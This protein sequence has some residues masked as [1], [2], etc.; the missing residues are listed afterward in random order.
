MKIH[1]LVRLSTG[2]INPYDLYHIIINIYK[3][4]EKKLSD[5]TTSRFYNPN[6]NRSKS[7]IKYYMFDRTRFK[8][9][10]TRLE[11]I[12]GLDNPGVFC[13]LLFPDYRLD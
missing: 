12:R 13:T 2:F 9:Y 3:A 5:W 1:I 10:N 4:K 7:L 11:Y 6:Y 8:G